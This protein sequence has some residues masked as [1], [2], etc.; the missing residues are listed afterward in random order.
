MEHIQSKIFGL[1]VNIDTL[2][3]TWASMFFIL[4]CAAFLVSGLSS[5]LA[6]FSNRQHVAEDIYNFIRS[7]VKEQIGS[8]ADHY[9]FFLGSIFL[10]VLVNYYAGLLPWKLGAYWDW[11]PKLPDGHPWHGASPCVDINIP[12]AIA[13][14]VI[15]TYFLSGLFVAGFKYFET[16]LPVNFSNGFKL[17]LMFLIEIMDL[18]IRPL[19]LSLRLFANT[20][21][22]E[23][24][25]ASFIA[26]CA[27]ILPMP[28]L[29]FEAAVG[30]LQAF[31][32]MILSTVYIA[33]AIK[34]AEHL[35]HDSDH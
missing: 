31:L 15:L 6:K 7:I 30:V 13:S 18:I 20:L 5:D 27:W 1:T 17:N 12:A 16:F 3:F 22:G 33:S 10:F 32:F 14:L 2:Y 29:V 8:R 26:L 35:L 21:A 23:I 11:W 25:L 9:V 24:L 28:I 34:H 4:L 19:T